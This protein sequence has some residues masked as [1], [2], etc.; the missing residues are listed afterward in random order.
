[1]IWNSIILIVALDSLYD[2]FEMTT[3]S[4]LYLDDKNCEEIQPIVTSIE[5]INHTK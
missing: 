5:V 3:V 4:L 2:N 1:M